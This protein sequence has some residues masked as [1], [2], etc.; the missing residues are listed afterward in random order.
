M[1]SKDILYL[2]SIFIALILVIIWVVVYRLFF[3]PLSKFPGPKLAAATQLYELYFD[4][5]KGG[6]FMWEIER[7]HREYGPIVLINPFEVHIMDPNYYDTLYAGPTRRR[8]KDPWFSFI[9]LPKS[10]FST[11]PHGLHRLRRNALNRFFSKQSIQDFEPTIHEKLELLSEHLCRTIKRNS[12]LDL[13]SAYFCFAADTVS[14]YT[15]GP[16][17]CFGY[18]DNSCLTDDWKKKV[19]SVFEHLILVRHIPPLLHVGRNFPWLAGLLVPKFSY[20]NAAET[21]SFF[22]SVS[23]SELI[24]QQQI[25][26]TVRKIYDMSEDAESKSAGCILPA[27]AASSKVSTEEKDLRR[28][29]D[30][31]T[32]LMVAGTDAPSQVLAITM[33]YMLRNTEVYWKIRNELETAFPDPLGTMSWNKLERIDYLVSA[34]PPLKLVLS[35]KI[36]PVSN[37]E[38]GTPY[39]CSCY[40]TTSPN[41]T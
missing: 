5:V 19:N 34:L 3:S 14:T 7:M 23:S 30:E 37:R 20:V 24:R 39:I 12:V 27:I 16:S 33:F 6:Q 21:V 15:F 8:D 22:L 18:L 36:A 17:G 28:M 29:T 2:L 41:C 35:L 31:A 25:R 32:F 9:G 10:T 26:A 40:H 4:V 11:A 38:R 13:H 1:A